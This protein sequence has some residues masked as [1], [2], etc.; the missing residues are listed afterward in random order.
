MHNQRLHSFVNCKK[1][2][3]GDQIKENRIAKRCSALDSDE[4]CIKL[5]VGK[6]ECGRHS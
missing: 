1:Y 3:Y 5:V 2:R 4:K 6:P